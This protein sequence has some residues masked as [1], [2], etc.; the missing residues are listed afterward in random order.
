MHLLTSPVNPNPEDIMKTH[1]H[2]LTLLPNSQNGHQE[3][4]MKPGRQCNYWLN[5]E[6]AAKTHFKRLKWRARK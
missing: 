2:P 4:C 3:A 5:T 1:T 6:V